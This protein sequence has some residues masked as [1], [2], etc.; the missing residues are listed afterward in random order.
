MSDEPKPLTE[1]D[2]IIRAQNFLQLCEEDDALLAKLR[3]LEARR[4]ELADLLSKA[5]SDL[6]EYTHAHGPQI[7]M[8]T[9]GNSALS[10]PSLG[11]GYPPRTEVY[12]SFTSVV[13]RPTPNVSQ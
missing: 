10:I 12:P 9:P 5:R 2:L 3:P 11:R 13:Q 6:G 4:R 7:V 1:A 8:L